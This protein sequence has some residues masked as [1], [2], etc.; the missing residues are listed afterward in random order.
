MT[1]DGEVIIKTMRVIYT[2]IHICVHTY[3]PACVYACVSAIPQKGD[4]DIRVM[5]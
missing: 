3:T 2:Y 5:L 1:T 4:K